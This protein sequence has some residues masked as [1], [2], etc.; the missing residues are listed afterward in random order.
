MLNKGVDSYNTR[1]NL[2]AL[3]TLRRDL[4]FGP[5][6]R[7]NAIRFLSAHNMHETAGHCAAVAAE[8]RKIAL[9]YGLDGDAAEQAGLLHDISAVVP[10]EQR[11]GLAEAIGLDLLDA[12]RAYPMIVHQRLSEEMAAELFGVRDA[13][14]L[15]AIGC[16]TTL[17]RGASALDKAVF[18]ADKIRWDQQGKPPY[19]DAITACVARSLD[20]AAHCY[21]DYLFSNRA[22]LKVVH[23]WAW[24][25]YEELST[26]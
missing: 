25:A 6:L 26:G 2:A 19:L 4:V 24:D 20:E 21:L 9:V 7:D 10:N 23:P 3:R 22:S 8:A 5:D 17:K 15:S 11:I 18:V 13:R 1:V 14:V 12:E 16:H